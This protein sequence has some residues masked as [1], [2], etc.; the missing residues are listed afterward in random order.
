MRRTNRMG[1]GP[2]GLHEWAWM[3]WGLGFDDLV[4]EQRAVPF[5]AMLERIRRRRRRRAWHMPRS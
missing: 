2:T 3:R 5:W 4:D 1:V